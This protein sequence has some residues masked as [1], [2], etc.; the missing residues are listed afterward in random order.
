MIC[1]QSDKHWYGFLGSLGETA[2]RWEGVCMGLPKQYK[3]HCKLQRRLEQKLKLKL[4]AS[5]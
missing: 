5:C 1:V 3:L 4:K 2:E